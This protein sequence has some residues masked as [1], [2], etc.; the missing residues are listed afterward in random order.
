MVSNTVKPTFEYH[1][2]LFAPQLPPKFTLSFRQMV[3]GFNPVGVV[4]IVSTVTIT[5]R[6][7]GLIQPLVL[8]VAV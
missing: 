3:T 2:K 7:T 5:G 6:E 4:G 8:Q 1:L